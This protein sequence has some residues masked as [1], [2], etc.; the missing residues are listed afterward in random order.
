MRPLKSALGAMPESMMATPMPVD[1]V[2]VDEVATFGRPSVSR[3]VVVGPGGGGAIG[4]GAGEIGAAIGGI[5]S[6][7]TV[8]I[9]ATGASS[10]SASTD[11]RLAIPS[12]STDCMSHERT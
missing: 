3:S 11:A 6:D 7:L 4:G 1:P 9:A 8:L 5:G 10:D 12:S 2:S